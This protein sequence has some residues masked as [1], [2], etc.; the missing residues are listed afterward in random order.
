MMFFSS[1]CHFRMTRGKPAFNLYNLLATSLLVLFAAPPASAQPPELKLLLGDVS[2]NKLPFVMAYE[3]GIYKKNGLNVRPM[4]SRGSVDIIRRSGVNIPEEFIFSG[5]GQT[6]IKIGGASP[7]MVRLT[8][9]TGSWDPIILGSTHRVSRWYIVSRDDITTP[10]QLKG[11]RIGYSGIGAVTHLVAISFARHMG[12]DPDLDW[13]MMGNGL[14]VEALQK[15]YVDAF[16]APELHTTM[17]VKAGFKVLLDLG[18]Y[19]FPIAGSS[20]LVDRNWLKDNPD[21]ARSF[22]KSAVEAIALIKNDKQ[23]AFRTLDKWYQLSEPE[24]QEYFYREAK[25]LPRKP[26]PPYAGIKKVMDIYD[27]HEMRKYSAEHFYDDSF[28]RELD[29]SGYIDSLYE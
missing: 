26:Y 20:I 16:I 28:I 10:E 6:E 9:K 24:I 14:G 17:A 2:L 8:T 21:A 5:N 19:E 18:E 25:K 23:A 22:V 1:A 11:K 4:F 3:E 12:W 27:S 7:T 15:G 13:S 29:E